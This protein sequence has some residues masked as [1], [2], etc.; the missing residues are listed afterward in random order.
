M[1]YCSALLKLFF[2]CYI[3]VIGQNQGI[4][5]FVLTKVGISQTCR[6]SF[7]PFLSTISTQC[8]LSK[9][10]KKMTSLSL[11]FKPQMVKVCNF[12]LFGS[13]YP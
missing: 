7:L 13:I 12:G 4:R 6:L 2:S 11:V 5:H 1:K 3:G 9:D 10:I 8:S